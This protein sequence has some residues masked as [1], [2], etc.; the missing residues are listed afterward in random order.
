MPR[1]CTQQAAILFLLGQQ[2][3]A[4]PLVT[5]R[6]GRH[7]DQIISVK[8]PLAVV[9]HHAA[10]RSRLRWM[11]LRLYIRD[12]P[13]LLAR[14]YVVALLAALT[15]M[16]GMREYGL[17][18]ISRL[19][20]AAV[21]G[22]RVA[23]AAGADLALGGVAAKAIVV[24][25]KRRWNMPSRTREI[26]ARDAALGG[27]RIATVMHR[28]VELHIKSLDECRRE[29]LHR[30]RRR[31]HVLMA[32]RAHRLVLV[33]ELVQVTANARLVTGVVHL[34]R[35]AFAVMT[36]SAVEL[37]MFFDSVRESLECRIATTHGHGLGS[38]GGCDRRDGAFLLL[39][40]ARGKNCEC[41]HD[42]HE[43]HGCLRLSRH[44][45]FFRARWL[46]GT[47]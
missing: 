30:R 17:E 19:R 45:Y 23:D 42:E 33:G 7:V 25:G 10:I 27:P 31:L 4:L 2:V 41:T 1:L 14:T 38:L 28:V 44:P 8:R 15:R 24:C 5:T 11:L 43:T 35:F 6:A 29:C 22:H 40:T 47:G 34:Q 32:D 12:L 39:E 16:R 36:R 21:R 37:L 46:A 26:V 20:R 18:D 9:A 3:E 13:P